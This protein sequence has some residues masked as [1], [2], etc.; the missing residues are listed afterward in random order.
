VVSKPGLRTTVIGFY[1]N[2]APWN[3]VKVRQ[4]LNYAINRDAIIKSQF[5]GM[6]SL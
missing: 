2:K 6:R 5:L 4:A 1:L 3:D